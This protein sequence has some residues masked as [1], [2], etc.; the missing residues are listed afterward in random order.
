MNEDTQC[1]CY[2]IK[3]DNEGCPIHYPK[4]EQKEI[5]NESSIRN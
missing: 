5:V 4:E 1:C 2:E 3:G